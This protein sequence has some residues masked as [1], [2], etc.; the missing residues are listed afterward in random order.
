MAAGAEAR[1]RLSSNEHRRPG[2]LSRAHAF[3]PGFGGN[4][5]A[6]PSNA[7]SGALSLGPEDMELPELEVTGT[8]QPLARR[9][10]SPPRRVSSLSAEVTSEQRKA[11]ERLADYPRR[12]QRLQRLW[13]D[14]YDTEGR[15]GATGGAAGRGNRSRSA[16]RGHYYGYYGYGAAGAAGAGA[17]LRHGALTAAQIQ[18]LMSRDLTPEDYELLLLLDE[19]VKKAKTLSPEAAAALPRATGAGWVNDACS[20][21]LCALEEDEDVRMLPACGHF[22]HATCAERWLTSSKSTCPVCGKEEAKQ[23]KALTAFRRFDRKGAGSF[24]RA[25]MKRVLI[26]L[27]PDAWGPDIIDQVFDVI[28]VNKDGQ[29]SIDNFVNWVFSVDEHGEQQRLC[30]TLDI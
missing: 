3:T 6:A 22:F 5:T 26:A 9:P 12:V 10:P 20:I 21:C 25:D 11:I 17:M 4:S 23:E 15:H 28:D 27:D 8:R 7:S 14:M 13:I 2:S 19:G 30:R 18:D 24:E 29:I 1:R 16:E